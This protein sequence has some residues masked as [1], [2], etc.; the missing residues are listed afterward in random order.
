[1]RFFDC[2]A[3]SASATDVVMW[4]TAEVMAYQSV[5]ESLRETPFW[6]HYLEIREILASVEKAYAIHS[7]VAPL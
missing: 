2:E 7:D 6:G 3:F 1:M 4:E 5:V